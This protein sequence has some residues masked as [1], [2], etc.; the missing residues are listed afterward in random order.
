MRTLTGFKEKLNK[1]V[2]G[3]RE[4]PSII[5]A[6]LWSKR[7]PFRGWWYKSCLEPVCLESV[8]VSP[9]LRIP[10]PRWPRRRC[11]CCIAQPRGEP[12]LAAP[13][14]AAAGEPCRQPGRAEAPREPYLSGGSQGPA[15]LIDGV[16]E[17]RGQCCTL[18]AGSWRQQAYSVCVFLP[19]WLVW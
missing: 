10:V 19:C 7:G 13:A 17:R 11:A 14:G 18:T 6:N 5:A 12:G 15:D 2:K 1:F 8:L 16:L 3:R 9:C 4:S